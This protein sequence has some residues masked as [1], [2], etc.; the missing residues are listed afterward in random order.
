MSFGLGQVNPA[1]AAVDTH[2][3]K[4]LHQWLCW[5]ERVESGEFVCSRLWQNYG[6]GLLRVRKHSFE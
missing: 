3:G 1:Y 4:R 6:L 2:G 5:T